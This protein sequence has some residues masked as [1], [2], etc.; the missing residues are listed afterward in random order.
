MQ[1]FASNNPQGTRDKTNEYEGFYSETDRRK[2][3]KSMDLHFEIRITWRKLKLKNT[4]I[5]LNRYG[6]EERVPIKGPNSRV[7][8]SPDLLGLSE[9][10]DGR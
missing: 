7:I 2:L 1:Y 3:Q 9:N 6:N 4:F 10:P 8:R 5:E